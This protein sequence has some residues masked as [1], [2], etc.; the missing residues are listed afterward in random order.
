MIG[1]NI[2]Q[3]IKP[4]RLLSFLVVLAMIFTWV[5]MGGLIFS[6]H[7][8]VTVNAS[9]WNDET[10]FAD[11][12]QGA[13]FTSAPIEITNPLFDV[14]MTEYV[15]F[16]PNPSGWVFTGPGAAQN[17]MVVAGAY[18]THRLDDFLDNQFEGINRNDIP[19]ITKIESNSAGSHV[20]ALANRTL[21]SVS[22]NFTQRLPQFHTDGFFMVTVDFY[23]VG[24][25]DRSAIYLSPSQSFTD[26]QRPIPTISVEQLT[27]YG[28]PNLNMGEFD[29][30]WQ[31][32]TFLVKT[33]ARA[34]IEFDLALHLGTRGAGGSG[35]VYYD[36]V[37]VTAFN[38]QLFY[39]IWNAAL[40]DQNYALDGTDINRV[41]DARN[42]VLVDLTRPHECRYTI[43]PSPVDF[44]PVL[45][46]NNNVLQP[47]NF[48]IPNSGAATSFFRT[49]GTPQD[50]VRIHP[51]IA[52]GQIHNQLNFV[53]DDIQ[54]L[55]NNSLLSNT[56]QDGV[57]MIAASSGRAG[58][59]FRHPAYSVPVHVIAPVIG[60][61]Q[62]TSDLSLRVE[63]H[64]IY[65]ISFYS[66]STTDTYVRITDTRFGTSHPDF[67]SPFNSN[68]ISLRHNQVEGTTNSRNGWIL[69]TIFLSGESFN[70]R[71]HVD[72]NIEF[73]VGGLN[74]TTGYL[75]IDDFQI[76]EVSTAY[77]ERHA[78][79]ENSIRI[80]MDENRLLD[81]IHIENSHFNFG[82]NRNTISMV[83]GNPVMARY[84]LVARGWGVEVEGETVTHHENEGRII[85]GI[86][87]TDPDHWMR[88]AALSVTSGDR[89][90]SAY[91]S[92]ANPGSIGT[93]EIV[94]NYFNNILMIQNAR[95]THQRV[96][97]STINLGMNSN[98]VISFDAATDQLS[99]N[100]VWAL[101]EV[102]GREVARLRLHTGTTPGELGGLTAWRNY[103][104]AVNTSAFSAPTATIS[105][106]LGGE[107]ELENTGILF[108]DNVL[109]NRVQVT[110]DNPADHTVDLSDPSRLYRE[111]GGPNPDWAHSLFF[112][113][114]PGF[115]DNSSTIEF[116]RPT[117]TL[118]V[119]ADNS[120]TKV[121]S[122]LNETIGVGARFLY[123][124][125]V[126]IDAIN[127]HLDDA[128]IVPNDDG[129]PHPWGLS[130]FLTDG[131]DAYNTSGGF[132][133]MRQSDIIAI[134]N[135]Q[136]TTIDVGTDRVEVIPFRFV[137]NPGQSIDL[138]LTIEFGSE[139]QPVTGQIGIVK[140]S[141][142]EI[143]QATFDSWVNNANTRE[144]KTS[145]R[146]QPPTEPDAEPTPANFDWLVLPTI[147]MAIAIIIAV[148]GTVLRRI[149]FR[150]HIAKSHTSYERDDARST[151]TA[152][153]AKEAKKPRKL[154][155]DTE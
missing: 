147:I 125:Y 71:N 134:K 111:T 10:R 146:P 62:Y 45:F 11:P 88:N 124:V 130:I 40:A 95:P 117:N 155:T 128:D 152:P 133:H 48:D 5:P 89:T 85:T 1:K 4:V 72:V 69:N 64:A 87:N 39:P 83:N 51:N 109:L 86:V 127:V 8:K 106:V 59:K 55:G 91:G 120:H 74:T 141:L 19:H 116:H 66:L 113:N 29:S 67:I 17:A 23:A 58:V 76:V 151:K 118:F 37:T 61:V 13:A 104:I 7:G 9:L 126:R 100:Q 148:V 53:T 94:R 138:A 114:A 16:Q 20:L 112:E 24:T 149:K 123:T 73:W 97:S 75:M 132:I 107:N 102:N 135:S 65:M 99:N 115:A 50:N 150:R 81:T 52:V 68:F 28:D 80:S 79:H 44:A 92:A 35:V 2:Q 47:V 105:F 122:V 144:I 60:P 46:G 27:S 25:R 154:K 18:D 143:S 103:S 42:T 49:I 56:Y 12:M 30:I 41:R 31:T 63:N 90:G 33:D 98:N 93:A 77:M 110:E 54:V 36:N 82:R 43:A 137:I 119:R 84:P 153:I 78:N 121:Q 26:S 34:S 142:E 145:I 101:V 22:A 129:D 70:D 96:T 131:R 136:R 15:H 21:G 140:T 14:G 38:E 139:Y 6:G 108:V 3:L 57:M 32:A